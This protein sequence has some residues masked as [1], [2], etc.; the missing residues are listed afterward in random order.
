MKILL[1][2]L[3]A[4]GAGLLIVMSTKNEPSAE[5]ELAAPVAIALLGAEDCEP[6]GAEERYR[7][8]TLT[9]VKEGDRYAVTMT[10]DGFFD[11][12]VKAARIRALVTRQGT[13]WVKSDVVETYQCWP[14]RGHQ[15]FSPEFCI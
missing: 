6:D 13:A 15:D 12:S 14:G 5:P 11:D 1:V 7:S 3:F 2:A 4:A 10:H 8:C 9:I